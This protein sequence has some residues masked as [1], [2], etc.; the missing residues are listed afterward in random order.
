MGT[1]ANQRKT[2]AAVGASV[3]TR[4]CSISATGVVFAAS[5]PL[6]VSSELALTIQTDLLGLH[7]EW[8][9]LGWVVECA[10]IASESQGLEFQVTLLFSEM[11]A[12]LQQLLLFTENAIGKRAYPVLK[13]AELFGLN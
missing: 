13:A 6:E 2:Q 11:P 7:R 9:V 3:V 10:P 12:G 5:Q 8:S 4:M 1:Q